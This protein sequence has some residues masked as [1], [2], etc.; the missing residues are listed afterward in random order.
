M[1]DPRGVRFL[2]LGVM[3]GHFWWG[4]VV[5]LVEGGAQSP[6]AIECARPRPRVARPAIASACGG[7]RA[8]MCS[9]SAP[10]VRKRPVAVSGRRGCSVSWARKLTAAL[11]VRIALST[12]GGLR[13]PRADVA[14][15]FG[16]ALPLRW[17][18]CSDLPQSKSQCVYATESGRFISNRPLDHTSQILAAKGFQPLRSLL[19]SLVPL[20]VNALVF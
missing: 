19:V 17:I 16:L 6:S 2:T 13:Q 5:F 11:T 9:V 14:T 7:F 12:R 15:P 18:C 4:E 3:R 10:G 20:V 1:S 8:F